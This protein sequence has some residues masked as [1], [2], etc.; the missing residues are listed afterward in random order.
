MKKSVSLLV[1]LLLTSV[2]LVSF[3]QIMV[4]KAQDTIYIR[5]DGSVEGTDK[6]QREGNI[7]TYLER[8]TS[9]ALACPEISYEVFATVSSQ[10]SPGF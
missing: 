6:I 7:Y 4:A 9:S 3:P 5:A 1:L 8:R 10:Y 2:V